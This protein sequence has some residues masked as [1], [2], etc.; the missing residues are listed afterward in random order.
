MNTA[1]FSHDPTGK[2]DRLD[3][4]M[5]MENGQFFLSHGGFITGFTKYGDKFTRPVTGTPPVIDL[6][7]PTTN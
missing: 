2:S 3:H 5:G 1:S 6:P 4:F 7:P